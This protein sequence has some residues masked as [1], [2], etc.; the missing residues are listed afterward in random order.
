MEKSLKITGLTIPF[1]GVVFPANK[2]EE[3]EEDHDIIEQA[4][5]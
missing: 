1:G 4:R 5:K 2:E 3:E